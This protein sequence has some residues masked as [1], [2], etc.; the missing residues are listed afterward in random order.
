[1]Y[2]KQYGKTLSLSQCDIGDPEMTALANALESASLIQLNKILRNADALVLESDLF[3]NI[4]GETGAT[5]MAKVLGSNPSCKIQ[6]GDAEATALAKALE[7]NSSLIS[8]D[9]NINCIGD[10]GA[11]ALAKALGSL[12]LSTRI[13]LFP[14]FFGFKCQLYWRYENSRPWQRLWN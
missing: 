4:I 5:A 13:K 11:A 1:M 12:C 8:L 3:G 14:N 6:I 10:T 2:N 7:S 9:L